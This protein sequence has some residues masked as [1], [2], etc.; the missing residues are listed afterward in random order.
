MRKERR[1]RMKKLLVTRRRRKEKIR[2]GVR[3]HSTVAALVLLSILIFSFLLINQINYKS[4]S[5]HNKNKNMRIL[6][7]FV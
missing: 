1:K 4:P 3:S 2:G 7:I 5:P 6:K